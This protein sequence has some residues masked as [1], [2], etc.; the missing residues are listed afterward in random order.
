MLRL[1][2]RISLLKFLEQRRELVNSGKA[3]DDDLTFFLGAFAE[4]LLPFFPLQPLVWLESEAA[5]WAG[6]KDGNTRAMTDEMRSDKNKML[7]LIILPFL[8]V[9]TTLLL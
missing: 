5:L 1:D 2:K 3:I 8:N 9:L 7:R 6:L 4:L